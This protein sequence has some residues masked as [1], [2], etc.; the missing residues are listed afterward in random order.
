[1]T[2]SHFPQVP[3]LEFNFNPLSHENYLQFLGLK[4][5]FYYSEHQFSI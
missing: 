5:V 4:T 2:V 3:L 1:M